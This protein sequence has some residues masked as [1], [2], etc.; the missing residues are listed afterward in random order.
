M[1]H[2]KRYGSFFED[3]RRMNTYLENRRMID[4]HNRLYDSGNVTYRMNLNE[5]S[6]LSNEEFAAHMY[7]ANRPPLK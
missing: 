4:E 3:G 1:K 7:G 6:D 5:Y 2:S